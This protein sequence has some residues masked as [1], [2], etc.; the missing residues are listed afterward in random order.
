MKGNGVGMGSFYEVKHIARFCKVGVN[1]GDMEEGRTIR[2]LEPTGPGFKGGQTFGELSQLLVPIPH[3]GIVGDFP[4][5]GFISLPV[6][7]GVAPRIGVKIVFVIGY[8]AVRFVHRHVLFELMFRDESCP[9]PPYLFFVQFR[10]EQFLRI[11]FS[12]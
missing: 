3:F 11:V 5:D 8:A 1:L 7:K 2:N 6:V 4:K 12:T 9:I 10:E